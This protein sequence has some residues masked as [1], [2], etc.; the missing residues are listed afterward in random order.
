MTTD[1]PAAPSAEADGPSSPTGGGSDRP[2]RSMRWLEVFEA[3]LLAVAALMTAWAAFQSTKWGGVQA[4]AYSQAGAART[5]S[6]RASNRAN[7]QTVVD[8]D[9]FTSW[10]SAIGSERRADIDNGLAD[11]GSYD[12][13]AGTESA[14]LYARFRPEFRVAVDAWLDTRPLSDPDAATTPFQL[15]QYVVAEQQRA[16]DLQA[17]ADTDAA[18]ARR[19]NQRGDNYVMMTITFAL[20][21]VLVGIGSKM[22]TWRVHVA[23]TAFAAAAVLA[24]VITLLTFPVEL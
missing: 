2:D 12:P 9:T 13:V 22:R 21:I 5:E 24:G 23:L 1:E 7:E 19:A 3:V 15:P 4:N 17:Q 10:V 18:I 6:V 16:D 14:F 8:V 11:D 20:A